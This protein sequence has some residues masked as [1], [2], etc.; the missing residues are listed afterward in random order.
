MYTKIDKKQ[1]KSFYYSGMNMRQVVEA[2]G[3]SNSDICQFMI[4]HNINARPSGSRACGDKRVKLDKEEVM[5][6]YESGMSQ[7]K[8]GKVFGVSNAWI[9]EFM[10]KHNIQTRKTGLGR[11][12]KIKEKIEN[13]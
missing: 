9:C 5:A 13:E 6:M 12:K 1:V 10:K 3:V 7:R 11:S 2:L 4:K 8:I